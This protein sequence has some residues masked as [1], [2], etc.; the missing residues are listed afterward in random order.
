MTIFDAS[1]RRL[2]KSEKVDVSFSGQPCGSCTGLCDSRRSGH[3]NFRMSTFCSQEVL[4]GNFTHVVAPICGL[5]LHISCE[6]RNY[7][8]GL[9]DTVTIK[10]FE[11]G[12]SGDWKSLK[13][14]EQPGV[15]DVF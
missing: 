2:T 1:T 9:F 7:N 11:R 15:H 14:G 8:L 4:I 10:L 13:T 12:V 5:L 6:Y 3:I